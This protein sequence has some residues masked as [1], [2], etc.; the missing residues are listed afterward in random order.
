[1]PFF[2]VVLLLGQNNVYV[3]NLSD[4]SSRIDTTNQRI[5]TLTSAFNST[6]PD[7]KNYLSEIRDKVMG[8]GIGEYPNLQVNSNLSMYG[9]QSGN[10]TF[11][12]I[13][14][15][16]YKFTAMSANLPLPSSFTSIYHGIVPWMADGR[17]Y[18]VAPVLPYGFTPWAKSGYSL[19]MNSMWSNWVSVVRAVFSIIL[20]VSMVGL[21]WRIIR[22]Y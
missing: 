18:D 16:E 7:M 12:E 8:D 20:F 14:Q 17:S 10:S 1:M 3:T 5:S 11:S 22:Q 4:L 21:I 13:D 9:W 15:D 6:I 19:N 2:V